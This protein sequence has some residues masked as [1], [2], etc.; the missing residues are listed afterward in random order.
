MRTLLVLICLSCFLSFVRCELDVDG[1]D[2][3]DE[4][5]SIEGDSTTIPTVDECFKRN[6]TNTE[7]NCCLSDFK[8]S[9]ADN[10]TSCMPVKKSKVK[11]IISDIEDTYKK[12]DIK[13]LKISID[14]EASMLK[15]YS[16]IALMLLLVF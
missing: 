1:I 4:G 9:N 12:L 11:D 5:C 16:M 8:S 6:A 10:N 14:C 13:D 2:M 7:Y 3:T 15:L